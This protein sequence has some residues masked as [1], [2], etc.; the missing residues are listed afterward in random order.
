MKSFGAAGFASA[1]FQIQ[2]P[3]DLSPGAF[4][5]AG[6]EGGSRIEPASV[7]EQQNTG[8]FLFAGFVGA[9]RPIEQLVGVEI[10][11]EEGRPVGN[12]A[13]DQRF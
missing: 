5:V 4:V 11:L 3:P 7:A 9:H 2:K 12:L 13:G 8:G 1:E 10:N 6:C